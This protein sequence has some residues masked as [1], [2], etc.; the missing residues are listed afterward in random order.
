M[1]NN[2]LVEQLSYNGEELTPTAVQLISYSPTSFNQTK[3]NFG[4]MK[5]SNL[6]QIQRIG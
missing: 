4:I 5:I 2:L 1:K 3:L 6:I